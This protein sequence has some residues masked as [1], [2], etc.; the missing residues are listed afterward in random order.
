MCKIKKSF[1]L[2]LFLVLVL[3]NLFLCEE[4]T[5]ISFTPEWAKDLIIYEVAIKGFTSPKGPESGTF[6]SLKEKMGYLEELGIN[7]IWLTGHSMSDSSHFYG[8]WTQYAC[9][10]PDKLDPSL[11]TEQEFKDMIAEA[12]RRGIRIFLDTIEH[13]V[14]SDS[15][16]VAKHPDWFKGGSWGMTDY[17]WKGDHPELEK[18]W[19]E[20]WTKAVLDWGVDGFRCDCGL[21]RPDLWLKVKQNCAEAGKPIFILGESGTENVSDA[22]QRDIM[23]FDQ[24]KGLLNNHAVLTNLASVRD[25]LHEELEWESATVICSVIYDNGMEM[26]NTG[27]NGGL[28]IFFLGLADDIIGTW[29]FEPDGKKDWQW[30]IKGV[31][32]DRLIKRV[33][34]AWPERNW[35]WQSEGWGWKMAV[36][37]SNKGLLIN[38]GNPLPGAKMRIIS[39]S[40]H[41]AGWDGF[42]ID[43]NPFMVQGSRFIFGYGVLF[44]PAIPIFM[45]GEEFDADYRPLPRHTP[46]LY[47]KGEPGTGRWLYG[48]WLNWEQLKEIPHKQMFDD[49]Q[50]M[51]EIRRNH[52]DLIHAV[53]PDNNDI[54]L[55]AIPADS[56]ENLPV[57][58]MLSNGKRALLIVGNPLN[59]DVDVE[60]KISAESLGLNSQMDNLNVTELWPAEKSPRIMNISKLSKYSCTV[61]ADGNSGGGLQ[62]VRFESVH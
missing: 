51:I 22:C 54:K 12:H 59:F 14:M 26:T 44:S 15:P 21:H 27:Q 28:Q 35:Q 2:I 31:D 25:L 49:V 17:D 8:I 20:M 4:E 19:V 48:A 43:K 45:S 24:R 6:N 3:P 55:T 50:R 42:P 34:L 10:E 23:L 40:C 52:Q 62:V 53:N 5:N 1:L 61:P 41:D 29:E 57:P 7:G 47:G 16:L 11:G 13:G 38:G 33:V 18:W 39:P 60:L 46:D 37:H 36:N 56:E 32:Q 30:L 9:I 58:Y